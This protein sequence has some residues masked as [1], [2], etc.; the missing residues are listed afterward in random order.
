ME[1]ISGDALA[2]YRGLVE[3]EGFVKYFTT[4]T[5]V[6]ELGS[7]NIGSRPA[8]RGGKVDGLASLRA[9]PWVFGWTQSRQI[10]PGWFGLGTSLERAHS[11]DRGPMIDEMYAEWSFFQTLVSNV[12]MA[13]VK[14]DMEI[15]E[16]YVEA[17]VDP[18]LH[19]I[20]EVI[21]TEFER[22]VREVLRV[23]GQEQL[24][25]RSPVLQRTL[26]VRAPYIDPLNYLQISLLARHRDDHAV[27]PLQERALLL[28]VNGIAAGLKNTG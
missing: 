19:P 17:L 3:T 11:G 26:N 8:R 13:L 18:S 5:P 14:T 12:E 20:F 24:L 16:R 9:I 1:T 15:A 25:D 4:S 10:I 2:A 28:T 22:T 27:D 6:E 23:T 21:R 7:M